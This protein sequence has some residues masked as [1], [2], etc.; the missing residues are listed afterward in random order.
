VLTFFAIVLAVY[1]GECVYRVGNGAIVLS[2]ARRGRWRARV[3]PML[4]LGGK[5][6]ASIAPL[7]PPL[8]TAALCHPSPSPSADADVL[9]KP[10]Q[11]AATKRIDQFFEAA[12]PVW[13]GCNTM[14]MFVWCLAPAIVF[15]RGLAGTWRGLLLS[16]LG[17]LGVILFTYWRAHR[18]LYPDA[19][20]ERRS[21]VMLMGVSPL[22]AIRAVD[23]LSHRVLA[24]M[25]PL[26]AATALCPR[27]ESVRLARWLY[28]APD[29]HDDDL[30]RFLE[31]AGLWSDVTAPP[32]AGEAGAIAFCP[33]C[34]A[35]YVRS[36]GTCSDCSGVRL[37]R[38][39]GAWG[40]GPR[41]DPQ[42]PSPSP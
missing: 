36:D 7:L 9:S 20:A 29:Q 6:G 24:E 26:V 10:A 31:N 32:E 17:I 12:R 5:G 13:I 23:H 41:V 8:A 22:G 33:R 38:G 15:F 16:G 11:K 2:G 19:K 3:G 25:H 37:V 14:W 30:R 42:A 35:Q 28:F 34:H 21:H 18:A 4:T 1:V 27:A 39:P 40:L